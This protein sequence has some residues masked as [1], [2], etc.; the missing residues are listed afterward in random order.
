MWTTS[1]VGTGP[2][3]L[4]TPDP[5]SEVEQGE[6]VVHRFYDAQGNLAVD[7]AT[8]QFVGTSRLR[9]LLW[10]ALATRKGSASAFPEF[11]LARIAHIDSRFER[12]MERNVRS[13]LR[14]V[15]QAGLAQITGVQ[16]VR[17]E[18]PGRVFVF[19]DLLPADPLE[20]TRFGPVL[21]S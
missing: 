2:M 8:R 3:A 9:Q 11:G 4:D 19:V 21:V 15:E 1:P 12:N 5:V 20:P 16:I 13:A 6:P 18:I 7:P 14:F 17:T 10:L